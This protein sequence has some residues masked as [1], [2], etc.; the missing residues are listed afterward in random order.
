MLHRNSISV[1]NLLNHLCF[2]SACPQ[3]TTT[4]HLRR[5]RSTRPLNAISMLSTSTSHAA[6]RCT[7]ASRTCVLVRSLM[8]HYLK[9]V[10]L[11]SGI[12]PKG[13][14]QPGTRQASAWALQIEPG[15]VRLGHADA[16]AD[17]VRTCSGLVQLR[18]SVYVDISFLLCRRIEAADE[19]G[20]PNIVLV[21][22]ETTP[23]SPSPKTSPEATAVRKRRPVFEPTMDSPSRD[24]EKKQKEDTDEEEEAAEGESDRPAL[25]DPLHQ[26]SPLPPPTLRAAQASF[27]QALR[28]TADAVGLRWRIEGEEKAVAA[29]RSGAQNPDS[30]STCQQPQDAETALQKDEMADST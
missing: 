12:A 20:Q 10:T 19:N 11:S 6:R 9:C 5:R 28:S 4:T 15:T 30:S 27:V 13:I 17:R 29:A 1:S 22:A 16:H 21:P 7:K 23:V 14:F 26:F 2:S 3:S 8:R 18:C 25:R 24:E